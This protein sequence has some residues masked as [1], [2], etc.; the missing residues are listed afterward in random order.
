VHTPERT[1]EKNQPQHVFGLAD[2]PNDAS[3][4]DTTGQQATAAGTSQIGRFSTTVSTNNNQKPRLTHPFQLL[5]N[6]QQHLGT[7]PEETKEEDVE[8]DNEDQSVDTLIL[9]YTKTIKEL[10]DQDCYE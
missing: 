2:K 4:S 1:P 3:V 8:M 5:D 10:E 9:H 7:I 6:D